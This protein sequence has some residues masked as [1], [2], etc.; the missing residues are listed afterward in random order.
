MELMLDTCSPKIPPLTLKIRRKV[1]V[2]T[3]S[4]NKLYLIII[5][6]LNIFV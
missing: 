2:N 3:F 4:W 6:M 5:S 1:E